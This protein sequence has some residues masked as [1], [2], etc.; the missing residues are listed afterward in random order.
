MQY[1]TKDN[2]E[3]QELVSDFPSEVSATPGNATGKKQ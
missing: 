1:E 2:S 3:S